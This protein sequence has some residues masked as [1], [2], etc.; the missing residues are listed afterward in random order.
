[1]DKMA[2]FHF[3]QALHTEDGYCPQWQSKYYAVLGQPTTWAQAAQSV[4]GADFAL[5]GRFFRDVH[6]EVRAAGVGAPVGAE[7]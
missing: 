6:Q 1:M 4:G 2:E 5:P 7:V 3:G